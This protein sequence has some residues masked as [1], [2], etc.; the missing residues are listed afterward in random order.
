MRPRFALIWLTALALALCLDGGRGPADRA[1]APRPPA[2]SPA[3]DADW[4]AGVQQD[5]YRAEYR[6]TWQE[7]TCLPGLARAY[8]APNR[9]QD[10]RTYFTPDGFRMTSRTRADAG[11]EWGLRLAAYGFAGDLRAPAAATLVPRD[12]RVEYRRGDLTEWYVN[13]E[14]GLEQGFTLA[15]APAGAGA[16]TARLVFDLAVTGNVTAA[17]SRDGGALEVRSRAG[18]HVVD[19]TGLVAYDAAGRELPSAMLL[20]DGGATVRLEV[21]ATGACYPVTVDPLSTS[22]SWS[23]T[24]GQEGMALGASVATAGDVNGDGYSD[25]IVGAPYSDNGDGGRGRGPALPGHGH[26]ALHRFGVVGLGRPR[27]C[28]PRL[29]GGHRRRRQRRRLQRRHRRRPGLRHQRLRG[30]RRVRLA[31]LGQ[32]PR[33]PARPER[34]RLDALLRDGRRPA[35]IRGGDGGRR[36]RRR[37]FGDRHRR[38]VQRRRRG[39]RHG[40][41]GGPL[42][43]R[44][45]G[46]RRQPRGIPASDR[47]AHGLD[48]RDRRRLQ[49]RRLRRRVPGRPRPGRR[50]RRRLRQGRGPATDRISA[51]RRHGARR[52]RPRGRSSATRSP[53]PATSTATATATC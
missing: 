11:W 39:D 28:A 8:H 38:P 53:P 30:G 33:R 22:P 50:E 12:N 14:R 51:S 46:Q 24:G 4:W 23:I 13:D 19:Y 21:D 7:R 37:V 44:H 45:G 40:R 26:G 48:R 52:A 47:R 9:A 34:R 29:V 41:P 49:R 16:A 18:A 43:Q 2:A 35:R 10:L 17:R 15:R 5:L 1:L 3:I 32:R 20:A 36:Q 31:R 6:V 42:R 25:V 27:R